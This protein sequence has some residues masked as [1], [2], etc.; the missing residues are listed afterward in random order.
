MARLSNSLAQNIKT[1]TKVAIG[2]F[3]PNRGSPAPSYMGLRSLGG[4]TKLS[5]R[6]ILPGSIIEVKK[7]QTTVRVRIAVGGGVI[8]A[9]ITNE[10]VDELK[11]VQ[12][13]SVHA[14]I[15][16]SDVTIAVDD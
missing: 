10:A 14:V 5:A 12:G 9:S 13:Q 3:L 7:G 6:N 16:A 15:K 11:L 4:H 2:T 1:A 8:T